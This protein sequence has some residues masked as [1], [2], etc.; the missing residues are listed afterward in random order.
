MRNS[1]FLVPDTLPAAMVSSVS[2]WGRN[3]DMSVDGDCNS[4]LKLASGC[5]DSGV[6]LS[7]TGDER[8]V[9]AG[10]AVGWGDGHG[11]LSA[12]APPSMGG[13]V[14]CK[15]SFNDAP[16]LWPMDEPHGYHKVSGLGGRSSSVI[17]G[18]ES[19]GIFTTSDAFE[20]SFSGES[21]DD[22]ESEVLKLEGSLSVVWAFCSSTAEILSTKY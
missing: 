14:T 16:T 1:L 7:D 20:R 19:S 4:R 13:R 2:L 11:E 9:M 10:D 17:A 8:G 12:L 22:S 5:T 21:D 15:V 6:G 18:A 3:C